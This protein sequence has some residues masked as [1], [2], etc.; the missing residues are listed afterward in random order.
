MVLVIFVFNSLCIVFVVLF[1]NNWY[2]K[3]KFFVELNYIYCNL[4]SFGYNVFVLFKS[5]FLKYYKKNEM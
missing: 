2:F 5:G 4:Y 1:F 3:F